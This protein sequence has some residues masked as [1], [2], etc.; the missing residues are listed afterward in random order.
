[1]HGAGRVNFIIAT[2]L[3]LYVVL[4]DYEYYM[5]TKNA[6]LKTEL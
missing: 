2:R 5:R 6:S 3:S 1:M 4:Y